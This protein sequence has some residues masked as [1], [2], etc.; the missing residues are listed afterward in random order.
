M[1]WPRPQS[2]TAGWLRRRPRKALEAAALVDEIGDGEAFEADILAELA[3][4]G[5]CACGGRW[6]LW[7]GKMGDDE[8]FYESLYRDAAGLGFGGEL[9]FDLGL[10]FEVDHGW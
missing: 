5:C 9:G 4:G 3:E 2:T 1:G 6:E 8:F 10:E 7:F